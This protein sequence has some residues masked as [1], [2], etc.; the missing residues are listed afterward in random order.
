MTDHNINQ[1]RRNF[2]TSSAS[3]LGMLALA[4]LLRDEGLLAQDSESPSTHITP[5]AKRCI[6]LFMEGGPSQMDL[7]DPKPDLNKLDGQPM[8]ESLLNEIKFAF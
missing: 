3:G 2:F 8:P 4:S 6:F 5:R 1:Q 7:F